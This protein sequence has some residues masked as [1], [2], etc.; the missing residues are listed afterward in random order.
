MTGRIRDIQHC[1]L[2]WRG[3]AIT[4]SYE[5]DWLAMEEL[6]YQVA[7]LTVTADDRRPLPFTETGYRSHFLAPAEIDAAGGPVAYVLAWLEEAAQSPEWRACDA[8]QAQLTLF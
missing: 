1:N 3:I 5:R 7:H 8:A 6:S 4:L 2:T